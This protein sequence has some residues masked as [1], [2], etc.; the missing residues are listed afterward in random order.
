L[1]VEELLSTGRE[2]RLSQPRQLAMYLACEMT[3]DNLPSIAAAF[4]R[5]H[6]TVVHARDKLSRTCEAD[7][8]LASVADRLRG[9]IHS[10]RSDRSA[11]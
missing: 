6:S 1:T 10:G 7:G 2:R 4:G 5:D 11:A 9:V 3:R 8:E